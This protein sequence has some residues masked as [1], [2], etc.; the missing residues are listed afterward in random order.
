MHLCEG[1]QQNE[2]LVQ[3]L[4]IRKPSY[5]LDRII[6]E[7]YPNFDDALGDLYHCLSD[8][9]LFAAMPAVQS[10]G[11]EV[12]RIHNCRRLITEWQAYVAGTRSLQKVFATTKGIVYQAE[13]Q[14]KKIHWQAPHALQQVVP[15]DVDFNVLLTFLEF[16]EALLAF[17]NF[18]LYHSMNVKYPP[19][20]DPQMETLEGLYT[21]SRDF[22]SN[23]GDQCLFKNMVF[24][25]SREAAKESLVFVIESFGGLVS[26][27]GDGATFK[28]SDQSITHQIFDRPTVEHVYLN[29]EYVLP[30]WVYDCVN[31][32]IILPTHPFTIGRIPPAH[33]SPFVESNAEE[34]YTP[35][36]EATTMT[37]VDKE[38]IDA[39]FQDPS[40]KHYFDELKMEVHGLQERPVEK[41]EEDNSES[42]ADHE[43]V[44]RDAVNMCLLTMS[45]KERGFYKAAQMGSERKKA[46]DV[47]SKE[48]KKKAQAE[49]IDNVR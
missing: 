28:E 46:N 48:R 11:I 34:S 43:Q 10:E 5:K 30:Q 14:G 35:E 3:Q 18:K 22:V 42:V 26:W 21:V 49:V 6:K 1:P 7:R 27:E 20:L 17:V 13:V 45:R 29:R 16:Y 15:G 24:F 32:K 38:S 23:Y 25:L 8:V 41:M 40:I 44:A 4:I 39:M 33:W 37:G 12:H 2:D 47:L 36:N 9:H 31:K 19:I